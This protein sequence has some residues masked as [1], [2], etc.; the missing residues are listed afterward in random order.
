M[1]HYT[2]NLAI[3]V[4][5]DRKSEEQEWKETPAPTT[6]EADPMA[7]Y[8]L[9]PLDDERWEDFL[10]KNP[11]SSVFHGRGWLRALWETYR[12]RP[13]VF[14][15]S[16]PGETL[17]N[18]LVF[19]EV[20][21]WL[22]G[23]RLVSLPFSDHCDLL[24]D[25][26]DHS[27][28]L[29]ARLAEA[30]GREWQYAEVRLLDRPKHALSTNWREVEGLCCHELSLDIPLEELFRRLHK[31]CIQRKVR[32]AERENLVYQKGNSEQ[33]LQQFYKLQLRTRLRHRLPPQPLQWFRNLI[34]C[35]GGNLT[36][37][38]ASKDGSAVAAIMTLSYKETTVY[39]YGCSDERL[40]HLGGMPFLFWKVIQEAK[41]ETM[42]RLDLGRSELTNP[43]LIAFKDRLGA[44]R[45]S[46]T[47]WYCAPVPNHKLRTVWIT[48]VARRF[49][50]RLPGVV[51]HLP[52]S[53]LAASGNFFYRH[54]D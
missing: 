30:V 48:N 19:C 42:R 18:G 9:D 47:N 16:R 12:Y 53:L 4:E 39:K 37:R 46:L 10:S 8:T 6:K 34:S 13:S 25:S 17:R 7:V 44:R 49:M 24:A 2:A 51:L 35:M 11:R 21:S 5:P 28:E 45:V 54:M 36:I 14:T 31:D 52:T 26:E 23:R 22:T 32:R 38:T 3:A 43:G 33:L 20:K 1:R 27:M 29:L 41:S 50:P 40:N 15:T